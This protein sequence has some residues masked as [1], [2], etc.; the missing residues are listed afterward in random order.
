MSNFCP[1]VTEDD[2]CRKLNEPCPRVRFKKRCELHACMHIGHYNLVKSSD[3]DKPLASEVKKIMYPSFME[4]WKSF[5]KRPEPGKKRMTGDPLEKAI[6]Q[7]L[8]R[9][10]ASCGGVTVHD[11]AM[12]F[13]IWDN[14]VYILADCLA[15]KGYYRNVVSVKT[16]IGTE[17]IRETFAYAYLAK[18]WLGQKDIRVYQIG[19][20]P[21]KEKLLSLVEAC[22]PY[23][24][25]VFSLSSRPYFDDLV[26]HMKR[27]F[28]KLRN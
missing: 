12:K 17:Q 16:W 14:N 25:G 28:M 11:K 7:V 5:A 26:E 24:D 8:A 3:K 2:Q 13:P 23:L 4:N 6:R 21:L 19:L 9:D 22:R 27:D 1:E 15:E 20:F 10:L 18:T